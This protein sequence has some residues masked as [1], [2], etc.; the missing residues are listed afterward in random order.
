[1]IRRAEASLL[2]SHQLPGFWGAGHM[3]VVI[4]LSR[5]LSA[6][7][8]HLLPGRIDTHFPEACGGGLEKRWICGGPGPA[9][10]QCHKPSRQALP[11]AGLWECHQDP[12]SLEIGGPQ[13][14]HIGKDAG[15]CGAVP[16]ELDRQPASPAAEST[17]TT[18]ITPPAGYRKKR[19]SSC[20]VFL[21]SAYHSLPAPG[22]RQ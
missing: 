21:P 17:P 11:P 18:N 6:D 12:G 3:T 20:R 1:M 22:P 19:R 10:R 5:R 15:F 9:G 7:G 2:K 13:R 4:C 8:W 16:A 14:S